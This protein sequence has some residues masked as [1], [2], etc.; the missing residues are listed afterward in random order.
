MIGPNKLFHHKFEALAFIGLVAMVPVIIA[1][2]GSVA[3]VRTYSHRWGPFEVGEVSDDGQEPVIGD[4][5]SSE[6]GGIFPLLRLP[7][8]ALLTFALAAFLFGQALS[9][10]LVTLGGYHDGLRGGLDV[11]FQRR[12]FIRPS[13]QFLHSCRRVQG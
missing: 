4:V 11:I 12:E 7:I 10:R 3:L 2:Q 8:G 9:G 13:V 6:L 5:E 1:S